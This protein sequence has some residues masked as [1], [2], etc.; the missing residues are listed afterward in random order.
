MSFGSYC[1]Y[2][3]DQRGRTVSNIGDKWGGPRFDSLQDFGKRT[4]MNWFYSEYSGYHPGEN[5]VTRRGRRLGTGIY[6][7]YMWK[8]I[9]QN[10]VGSSSCW[11]IDKN[12]GN[13]KQILHFLAQAG[14]SMHLS[15]AVYRS[16]RVQVLGHSMHK[17]N[18]WFCG[19]N[20]GAMGLRRDDG[21]NISSNCLWIDQLIS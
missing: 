19:G 17:N 1:T 11:V 16:L 9:L 15:I 7:Y 13:N 4:L 18:F 14:T 8:V 12:I 5:F 3:N 6:F 2:C 20:A 10:L 21:S